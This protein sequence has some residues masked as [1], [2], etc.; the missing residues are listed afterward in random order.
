MVNKHGPGKKFSITIIILLLFILSMIPLFIL[1]TMTIITMIITIITTNTIH[2]VV[3]KNAQP[4]LTISILS[5]L[6]SLRNVMEKIKKIESVPWIH[7]Q[8][9]AHL[10]NGLNG[11]SVHHVESQLKPPELGKS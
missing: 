2:T 7:V 5:R 10:A 6:L 1:S 11:Q 8:L 4:Q 9:I 3:I